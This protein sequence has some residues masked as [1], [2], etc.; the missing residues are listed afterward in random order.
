MKKVYLYDE[1]GLFISTYSAQESPLEPG[2]YITPNLSTDIEPVYLD[3]TWCKFENGVWVNVAD[4]RGVVW[5]KATGAQV[6]YDELGEL[7]NYLTAIAK[8]IGYYKWS[9]AEWIIDLVQAQAAQVAK[10]EA[11]YQSAIQA[12]IDYLGATFNADNS[13]QLLLVKVLSASQVPAGFFWQDVI[14]AQIPM[15]HVQLQGFSET[16]LIRGQLAFVKLQTLKSE[17]R[18]ALD[19]NAIQQIVW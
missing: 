11:S 19:I 14:N 12:D 2:V 8:P 15:T 5:D 13:S 6:D 10:I 18:A 7:P 9:G 3:K 1:N 4:N 17:I 16:I